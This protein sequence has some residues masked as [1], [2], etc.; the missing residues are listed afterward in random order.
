MLMKKIRD[1]ERIPK[2]Y[3]VSYYNP[4]TRYATCYI[5]PVN[6]IVSFFKSIWHWIIVNHPTK[7]DELISDA[8]REGRKR[9]REV[10]LKNIDEITL[11]R[12][13]ILKEEMDA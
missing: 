7:L 6:L 4:L 5:I 3:G 1:G 8:Y 10:T 2:G 9:E 12:M 13:K 11:R